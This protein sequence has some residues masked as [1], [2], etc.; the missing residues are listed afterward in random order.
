M[1]GFHILTMVNAN[2]EQ[3]DE[4]TEVEENSKFYLHF[5]SNRVKDTGERWVSSKF[6]QS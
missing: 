5:L 2:D 6:C 4:Q 1:L 3:N